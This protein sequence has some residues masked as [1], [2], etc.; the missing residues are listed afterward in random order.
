[1]EELK[2]DYNEVISLLNDLPKRLEHNT[3]IPLNSVAYL[4]VKLVNTNEVIT[5][6][7]KLFNFLDLHVNGIRLLFKY[8]YI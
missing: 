7:N 3:I 5:N 6:N 4:D 1:M 2:P 8:F